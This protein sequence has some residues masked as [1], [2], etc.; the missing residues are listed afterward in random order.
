MLFGIHNG[1]YSF[2]FHCKRSY[3]SIF[4]ANKNKK[5]SAFHL[6]ITRYL[7][8]MSLNQT[9]ILL[10]SYCV[11]CHSGYMLSFFFLLS[12]STEIYI[13][14]HEQGI[15]VDCSFPLELNKFY[16]FY[17]YIDGIWKPVL[18]GNLSDFRSHSSFDSIKKIRRYMENMEAFRLTGSRF[19][20]RSHNVI[21]LSYGN[22]ISLQLSFASREST[23][24]GTQYMESHSITSHQFNSF[25]LF[26]F[27]LSKQGIIL[28]LFR[29]VSIAN[30]IQKCVYISTLLKR[31]ALFLK[32]LACA[33]IRR[34]N[35]I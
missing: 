14:I 20:N 29:E 17:V 25:S 4:D 1:S 19:H 7:D 34:R 16:F 31:A 21:W 3:Y 8:K 30:F 5:T 33:F 35:I 6:N 13:K 10:Q 22:D 15:C 28:N 32:A 11:D 27:F 9:K 23:M 2:W 26:I 24:Y 12:F 18:K